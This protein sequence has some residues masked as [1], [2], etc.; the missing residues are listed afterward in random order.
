MDGSEQTAI[1]KLPTKYSVIN[2]RVKIVN[3]I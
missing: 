3:Q 2:K 1:E